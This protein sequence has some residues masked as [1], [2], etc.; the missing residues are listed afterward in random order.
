MAGARTRHLIF[1][2]EEMPNATEAEYQHALDGVV[3]AALDFAM[4][5]APGH[6]FI[7]VPHKDRHH[8]H[9][10]L[11]LCASDSERCIDWGVS[12]LK[13]FQGLSGNQQYVLVEQGTTYVLLF[14][15]FSCINRFCMQFGRTKTQPDSESSWPFR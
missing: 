1:S 11:A 13:N 4:K 12:D 9:C 8:P 14:K 7:I 5:E 2:A 10:H 6:D 15:G 3:A